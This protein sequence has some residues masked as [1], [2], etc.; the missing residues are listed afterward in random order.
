MVP[1]GSLPASLGTTAWSRFEQGIHST[2]LSF[3]SCLKDGGT[4]CFLHP[5]SFQELQVSSEDH[6]ICERE[7]RFKAAKLCLLSQCVKGPFPLGAPEERS[8]KCICIDSQMDQS[9]AVASSSGTHPLE[10]QDMC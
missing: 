8:L 9:H 6:C 1:C 7:D 2:T 4:V 5:L 3:L 10:L